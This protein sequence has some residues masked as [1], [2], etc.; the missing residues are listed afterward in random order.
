VLDY[1]NYIG[2][3][4]GHFQVSA[5]KTYKE[6]FGSLKSLAV[7]FLLVPFLAHFW[8]TSVLLFRGV[9]FSYFS[10]LALREAYHSITAGGSGK[11]AYRL[12]LQ[13]CFAVRGGSGSDEDAS[14]DEVEEQNNPR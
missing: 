3:S 11:A 10:E 5:Q 13:L 6:P 1:T 12:L 7:S 4:I 2:L 8:A 14:E 9:T